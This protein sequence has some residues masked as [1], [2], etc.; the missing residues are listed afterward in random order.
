MIDHERPE[1]QAMPPTNPGDANEAERAQKEAEE[2][3]LR[4]R[5]TVRPPSR[6]GPAQSGTFVVQEQEPSESV[7]RRS[8][9]G[10]G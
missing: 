1:S 2:K 9:G 5:P 3:A 4:E 8:R 7:A 6:R 10:R